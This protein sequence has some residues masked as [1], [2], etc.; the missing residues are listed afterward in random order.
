[1]LPDRVSNPGSLTYESGALA[2]VLCSPARLDGNE[3][4][5]LHWHKKILINLYT[6]FIWL[7]IRREFFALDNDLKY[8]NKSCEIMLLDGVLSSKAIRKI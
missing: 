8:L 5:F 2:I 6:V 4:S 3:L 1:M 7:V